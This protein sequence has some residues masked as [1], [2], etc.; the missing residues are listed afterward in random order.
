M[1]AEDDKSLQANI[2]R[3]KCFRNELCH[4]HSTGI[5][6]SEFGDKWNKI[7]SS[8]E[9]IEVDI[10]R[11]KIQSLKN[12]PI[13]HDTRR[14][15]E[16]QVERWRIFQ[17]QH[18]DELSGELCSYLPVKIPDKGII[19]RSKELRQVQEYIQSEAVS[20]VLIT[21][22]NQ[23]LEKQLWQKQWLTNWRNQKTAKL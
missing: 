17:Q 23:D 11:K 6:N 1:P 15:V 16:E 19:G 9:A 20:V 14:T 8:L 3:I 7:S 5:P 22:G 4:S 13:D 2:T 10:Y 18:E 21:G 12:D